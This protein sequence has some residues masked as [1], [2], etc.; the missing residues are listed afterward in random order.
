MVNCLNCG[1]ETA[2]PRYCSRSCSAI[3]TNK[4]YVKHKKKIRYCR[5]CGT[6]VQKGRKLC[7]SCNPNSVPWTEI[8]LKEVKGKRK[9]QVHSRIRNLARKSF[10]LSG[11]CSKCG[12]NKHTEIH[13]I[14]P[15]SSFSD[16]SFISDINDPSNL[17][18]LC[19]NCHWEIDHKKGGYDER[20]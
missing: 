18:E 15:I 2:N 13:H 12:Y 4:I 9:Y 20:V 14:N 3:N 7:T 8:T 6:E 5:D 11:I 17:I 19:P 10:S 1:K 16:D